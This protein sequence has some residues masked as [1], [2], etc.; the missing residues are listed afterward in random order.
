MLHR[1][2]NDFE[3]IVEADRA[4]VWHHLAQHKK[5]ETVDPVVMVEGRG[6]RVWNATGREHIDAVSGGVWT[7]NV[8]Y[9]RET[10]A[11]AVRDQLVKLNFFAHTAGNAPAA[12]FAERLIEKMPGMS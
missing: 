8:G 2:Q 10:I 4:N 12:L 1:G 9:G 6:L 5:F 11:N 7:V 3:R